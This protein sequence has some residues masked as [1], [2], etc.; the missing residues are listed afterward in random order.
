VYPQE[1]FAKPRKAIGA[2]HWMFRMVYGPEP[3]E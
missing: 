1:G 2:P 3:E